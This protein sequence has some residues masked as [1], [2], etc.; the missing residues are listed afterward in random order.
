[1]WSVIHQCLLESDSGTET[2]VVA[3]SPRITVDF[4][5]VLTRN[6]DQRTLLDNPWI[7]TN[8]VLNNLKVFHGDQRL[9]VGSF[10]PL[11]D[12]LLGE[13]NVAVE[14]LAICGDDYDIGNTVRAL[15]MFG[16]SQ[17]LGHLGLRRLKQRNGI[18]IQLAVLCAK[19]GDCCLDL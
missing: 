18:I 1:M 15:S 16:I 17:P 13:I 3:N 2:L 9:N 11:D 6:S 8:H 5:H 10:F 7:F 4:V 19:N 12:L 14:N